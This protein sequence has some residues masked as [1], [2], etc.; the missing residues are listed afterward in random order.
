MPPARPFFMPKKIL[1]LGPRL[2]VLNRAPE[3]VRARITSHAL[4]DSGQLVVGRRRMNSRARDMSNLACWK[5]VCKFRG[6]LVL[7]LCLGGF[8][9]YLLP[10]VSCGCWMMFFNFCRLLLIL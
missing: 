6:N 1:F 7:L 8:L 2:I 4:A 3:N 9:W 10:N 5:R